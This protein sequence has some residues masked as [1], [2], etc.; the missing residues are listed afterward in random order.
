MYM[1]AFLV[2]FREVVKKDYPDINFEFYLPH[3]IKICT[4]GTRYAANIYC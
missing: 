4:Y 1:K 3:K 2:A